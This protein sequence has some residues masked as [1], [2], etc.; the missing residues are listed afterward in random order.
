[1]VDPNLLPQSLRGERHL[2]WRGGEVS[3][4]EGLSDAVFALSLTLLVVALEVPKTS[5]DLIA[6]F[7]QFPAFA[8]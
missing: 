1:M 8:L 7:G 6:V 5:E 3:R 4:I 2:R